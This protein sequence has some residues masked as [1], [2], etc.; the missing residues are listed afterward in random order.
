[1]ND[2]LSREGIASQCPVC[3]SFYHLHSRGDNEPGPNVCMQLLANLISHEA[4]TERRVHPSHG[5][6]P[7]N[8]ELKGS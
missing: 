6:Y 7:Q 4:L 1:M 2:S 3:E 8:P 5:S